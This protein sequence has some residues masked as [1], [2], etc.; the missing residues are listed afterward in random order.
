MH[1]ALVVKTNIPKATITNW[2]VRWSSRSDWTPWNHKEAHG[3]HNRVF[4]P[5]EEALMQRIEGCFLER[6]A[7]P[8]D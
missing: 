5:A 6:G 3:L 2:R 1:T 8:S 4:M 7:A